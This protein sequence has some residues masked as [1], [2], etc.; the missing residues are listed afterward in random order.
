MIKKKPRRLAV[1][2]S[3]FYFL[4]YFKKQN[5]SFSFRINRRK[6]NAWKT[7]RV[8]RYF[9]TFSYYTIRRPIDVIVKWNLSVYYI[10]V[11]IEW[12]F[13]FF[14]TI[15][16]PASSIKATTGIRSSISRTEVLWQWK[17][18]RNPWKCGFWPG[19]GTTQQYERGNSSKTR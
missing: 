7:L 8:N 3:V 19:N 17:E 11:N 6:K 15:C 16:F 18:N 10:I 14:F 9:N 4:F 2:N 13:F 1:Y 12:F 5:S